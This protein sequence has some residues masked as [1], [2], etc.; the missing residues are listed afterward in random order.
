MTRVAT[1]INDSNL[2]I[3]FSPDKKKEKRFIWGISV[4]FI[5]KSQNARV[6]L[7]RKNVEMALYEL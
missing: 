6:I 2:P 3:T 1:E 5:C 4:L 7:F